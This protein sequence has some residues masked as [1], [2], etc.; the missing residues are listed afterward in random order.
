MTDLKRRSR[1]WLEARG[2]LVGNVEFFNFHTKRKHDLFGFLDLLAVGDN[3]VIGVQTTSKAHRADHVDKIANH[4]NV[5]RVR[6]GGI[7]IH[8]HLWEKKG[9]R[10]LLTVED[11]S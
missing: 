9:G 7:L 2:Y 5:G 10:W 11:L 1:E 4:E 6:D 3:E 8:L